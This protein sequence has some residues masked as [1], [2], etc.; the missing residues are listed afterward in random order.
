MFSSNKCHLNS[1]LAAVPR[2]KIVYS[3][4]FFQLAIKF[5]AHCKSW[6]CRGKIQQIFEDNIVHIFNVHFF[7][8]CASELLCDGSIFLKAGKKYNEI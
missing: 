2:F 3:C 5:V 6:F 8:I 4:L 1:N 7:Q